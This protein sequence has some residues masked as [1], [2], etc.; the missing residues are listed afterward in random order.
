MRTIP[1]IRLRGKAVDSVFA[2]AP[3]HEGTLHHLLYVGE[4]GKFVLRGNAA[5]LQKVGKELTASDPAAWNGIRGQT[6]Q[7][8]TDKATNGKGADGTFNGAALRKAMDALGTQRLRALFTAEELQQLQTLSKAASAATETPAFTRAG[9][10]SNTAEKLANMLGSGAGLPWVNKF[11]VEPVQS[12]VQHSAVSQSLPASSRTLSSHTG[13]PAL[14]SP[15]ARV[16]AASLSS[17]A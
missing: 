16:N 11:I 8:L 5:D 15:R 10:G 14:C 17:D 13:I 6:V 2:D 7:W 12:A 9:I 1:S 4:I 3:R